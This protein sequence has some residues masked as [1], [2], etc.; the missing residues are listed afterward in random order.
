MT[1]SKMQYLVLPSI[2]KY[3]MCSNRRFDRNKRNKRRNRN[4]RNRNRNRLKC[5]NT[6]NFQTTV[7]N[8]AVLRYLQHIYLFPWHPPLWVSHMG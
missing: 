6:N 7:A 4:N 5:N 8:V 1:S 2:A 3:E